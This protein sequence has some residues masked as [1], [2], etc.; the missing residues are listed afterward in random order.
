[1]QINTRWLFTIQ[2]IATFSKISVNKTLDTSRTIR[3]EKDS[4]I[5]GTYQVAYD[6]L[7]SFL[8]TEL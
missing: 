1:M 7:D 6:A 8:I 3:L 4:V 2:G 5:C